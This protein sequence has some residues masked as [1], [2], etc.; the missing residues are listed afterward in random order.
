MLAP[1]QNVHS[2]NHRISVQKLHKLGVKQSR[3]TTH[4]VKLQQQRPT[5]THVAA[6]TAR[7]SSHSPPTVVAIRTRT[8][9]P[10]PTCRLSPSHCRYRLRVA[11]Y[12]IQAS[13][14]FWNGSPLLRTSLQND[15]DL[16]GDRYLLSSQPR[17][18]C[19]RLLHSRLGARVCRISPPRWRPST[20]CTIW[21]L[22][23]PDFCFHFAASSGFVHCP[24]IVFHRGAR[25]SIGT[26][27]R[28]HF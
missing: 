19:F 14:F 22:H 16:D 13:F 26:V 25:D 23:L 17:P 18:D 6:V 5:S 8:L 7:F 1:S 4:T 12:I 11:L 21:L 2:K 28:F 10:I 15:G 20:V 9:H 27:Q 24:V 3:F